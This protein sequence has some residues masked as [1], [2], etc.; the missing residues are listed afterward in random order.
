MCEEA[1]H[2]LY[3]IHFGADKVMAATLHRMYYN[4]SK[5]AAAT[6][7]KVAS[8]NVYELSRFLF[9]LG[10][11]AIS[12]LV[13]TEALAAKAKKYAPAA[14]S[15]KD[16][17]ASAAPEAEVTAV[18]AMEEEMGCA[19][20][21][22]ADHDKLLGEIVER[23]VVVRNMLGKFLPLILFIVANERKHFSHALV[24]ETSILTLCRFMAT[25]SVVCEQSL[26]LLFTVLESEGSEKNR[27]SIVITLGDLAFRFPNLVE[28]WTD[29]IYAK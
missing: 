5:R 11:T 21:A 24:R 2:A 16:A 28:P 7:S 3:H 27:T 6:G 8:G 29:R 15:K 26:P 14:A 22:D 13:F 12:T 20:A 4:L 25:S 19:A 10:Q 23:E 1:V 18:D 17:A 9:V